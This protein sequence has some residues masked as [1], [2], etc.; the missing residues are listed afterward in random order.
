LDGFKN[1]KMKKET[2]SWLRQYIPQLLLVFA[3]ITLVNYLSFSSVNRTLDISS[4]NGVSLWVFW[5]VTGWVALMSPLITSSTRL[6]I[7][8]Y[9]ENE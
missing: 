4:W 6:V 1:N 8:N 5:V 9:K 7:N 2:K 3:V